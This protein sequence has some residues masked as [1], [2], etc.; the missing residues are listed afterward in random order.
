MFLKTLLTCLPLLL[1]PCLGLSNDIRET[2]LNDHILENRAQQIFSEVRCMVCNGEAIKD[3]NA[4]LS[5]A[6]R[7]IIRMKIESGES[8][9]QIITF[10]KERY[11]DYAILSPPLRSNTIWLWLLPT[12]LFTA[13]AMMFFRLK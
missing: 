2:P 4:H 8:N 11:G 10:I 9:D 6:M 7:K 12:A 13:G 3:S 1:H 5:Q